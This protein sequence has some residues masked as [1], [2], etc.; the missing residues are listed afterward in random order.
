[1]LFN[2]SASMAWHRRWLLL[3]RQLLKIVEFGALDKD[4]LAA[5]GLS[6]HETNISG[7]HKHRDSQHFK[8]EKNF[9]LVQSN[10][11]P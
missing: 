11:P 2:S 10:L 4:L 3:S 9:R 8:V 6:F 7:R 1:M 5:K